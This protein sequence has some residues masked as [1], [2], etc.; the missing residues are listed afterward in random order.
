MEKE[1]LEVIKKNLPEQAAGEMKAFIEQAQRDKVTLK[2][3]KAFNEDYL[4][5][6][7]EYQKKEELYQKTVKKVEELIVIENQ[8][9]EKERN[10]E[11]EKLKYQLE[12]VKENKGEIFRL[13]ETLVKNPRSIE[14]INQSKMVPVYEQYAGGGGFHTTKLESTHGTNEKTEIKD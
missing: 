8:L 1:L 13:V 5:Q 7:K 12:S 11:I 2:E 6:I 9:K 10:L 14:V 3:L 4:S